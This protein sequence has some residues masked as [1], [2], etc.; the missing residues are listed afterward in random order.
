MW[1][2]WD[3]PIKFLSLKLAM[4]YLSKETCPRLVCTVLSLMRPEDECAYV[5]PFTEGWNTRSRSDYGDIKVHG[6]LIWNVCAKREERVEWVR[7]RVTE[8]KREGK[9]SGRAEP[10]TNEPPFWWDLTAQK[11][12]ESLDT[13]AIQHSLLIGAVCVCV[14]K[15]VQK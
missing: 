9:V 2:S 11:K 14:R 5:R 8:S 7:E 4:W 13:A 15:P 1:D 3:S 6:R 10:D 12:A